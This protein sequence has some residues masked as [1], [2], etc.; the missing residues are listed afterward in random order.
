[1]KHRIFFLLLLV[2]VLASFHHE[3]NKSIEQKIIGTWRIDFRLRMH[4]SQNL[5]IKLIRTDALNACQ[6]GFHFKENGKFTGKKGRKGMWCGIGEKLR[7]YTGKWW[8]QNDSFL[9]RNH[10]K[11]QDTNKIVSINDS[12]LILQ[13]D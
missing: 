12:V 11:C 5:C 6:W 13:Y 3:E 8:I 2:Y 4:S 1:M 7:T 9:V 10:G